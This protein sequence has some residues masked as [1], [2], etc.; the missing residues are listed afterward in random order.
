MWRPSQGLTDRMYYYNSTMSTAC[1]SEAGG[2]D[3][4]ESP[5]PRALFDSDA[6]G[7]IPRLVDVAAPADRDVIRQQLERHDHQ[8]RRQQRVRCRHG[9][10]EIL[11][12]VEQLLDRVVP[13]RSQ[14]DY[15]TAARIRLLDVADHLLVHVVV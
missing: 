3:G 15:G 9:N 1:D 12:R 6:L 13:L 14:R 11:R 8:N 2:F 7:Q 4:A 5:G 10:Q